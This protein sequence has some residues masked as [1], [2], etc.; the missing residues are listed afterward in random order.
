M[1]SAQLDRSLASSISH[2][3]TPP[4]WY[5]N[6]TRRPA[7][8]KQ[9]GFEAGVCVT[10]VNIYSSARLV[11]K[12]WRARDRLCCIVDRCQ[13]RAL[14]HAGLHWT[15]FPI[16]TILKASRSR[17][18]SLSL[19]ARARVCNQCCYT[20]PHCSRFIRVD[21]LRETARLRFIIF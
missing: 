18:L 16:H 11:D 4:T 9:R 15:L 8:N 17:S 10:K 21:Q 19:C 3:I 13:R 7:I 1:H 12:A 2:P 6:V 20:A 14:I 5:N